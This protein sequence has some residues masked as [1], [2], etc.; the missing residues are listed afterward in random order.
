MPLRWLHLSHLHLGADGERGHGVVLDALLAAFRDGGTLAEWRPDLV[1]CTGDVGR[2][3]KA[4]EYAA[5]GRFFAELARA[6]GVLAERTFVVPGGHD[7]D[8]ARVGK[9]LVLQLD[10][11]EAA[12][13]FFGPDGAEER[14]VVHRR[15]AALADFHR[16]Q[17]GLVVDAQS[18]FVVARRRQP[19]EDALCV[20][21]HLLVEGAPGSG[22]T[23]VLKH[24]TMALVRAHRGD[25]T[26]AQ[27]MGFAAPF[28]LPIV[29]RLRR[30]AGRLA[31]QPDER[32]QHGG[33]ELLAEY[34][35]VVA[36]PC[37][38]GG[39]W[40]PGAIAAGAVAVLLDGLDE[41]TDAGRASARPT[42]CA[43]SWASTVRAGSC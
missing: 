23:T 19:I 34:L 3:G 12:D 24:V 2:A 14:A 11:R 15:L 7:V 35:A 22:K 30:F 25:P 40:I 32:R 29:V 9:R 13:E 10:D 5:A 36:G 18:P 17:L 38:G 4:E 43:T 26:R 16:D 20:S 1:F 8:R 39:A 21:R 41:I 28:P 27:A 42:S 31:G 33:A 37:S 6:T